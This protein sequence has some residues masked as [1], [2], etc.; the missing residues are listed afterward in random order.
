MTLSLDPHTTAPLGA[1]TAAGG[2][3]PRRV[4]PAREQEPGPV[5]ADAD[6]LRSLL[7]HQASTV[8]VVTAPG[9]PPVGFTATSFTSVSLAPPL[10]SVCLDRGSSSWPTVSRARHLAVH[11]LD[12]GQQGLARRFATSGVDRFAGPTRWRPGPEGVP[13][14]EETLA[15]LLCRV[16]ERVTAGDHAILLAEPELVRHAAGPGLPLLYH[17][18]RYAGLDPLDPT[19][20]RP[21]AA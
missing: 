10:V 5:D 12:A 2:T 16:V 14:L 15:W 18:G 9:S 19:A 1:P 20:A 4:P 7:R 13:I 6:S 11:L 8:T 3:D 17:R 21:A